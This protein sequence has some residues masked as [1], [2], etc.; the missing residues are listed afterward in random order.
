MWTQ[1]QGSVGEGS[2]V[3]T[4]TGDESRKSVTFLGRYKTEVNINYD[5]LGLSL[6]VGNMTFM[7]FMMLP[8]IHNSHY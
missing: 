6:T 5:M 4:P 3:S 1:G 8:Q 2:K 7:T